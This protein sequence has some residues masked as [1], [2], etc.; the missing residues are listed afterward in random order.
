MNR[1]VPASSGAVVTVS[2]GPAPV[3]SK[4]SGIEHSGTGVNPSRSFKNCTHP[5]PNC[6]TGV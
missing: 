6:A 1:R 2:P 5:P 3:V 4:M